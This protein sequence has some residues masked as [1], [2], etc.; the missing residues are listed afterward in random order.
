MFRSQDA[1]FFTTRKIWVPNGNWSFGVNENLMSWSESISDGTSNCMRLKN[2]FD[3]LVKDCI[4]YD[5]I[6]E[7]LQNAFPIKEN[8]AFRKIMYQ[9]DL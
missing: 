8:L 6:D 7:A 3:H 2:K 1:N 9:K 4:V 5:I